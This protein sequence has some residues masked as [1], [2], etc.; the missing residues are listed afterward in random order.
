MVNVHEILEGDEGLSERE[1]AALNILAEAGLSRAF[2]GRFALTKARVGRLLS[3]AADL[4]SK[5]EG[6]GGLVQVTQP[7]RFKCITLEDDEV[8]HASDSQ[9]SMMKVSPTRA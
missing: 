2:K 7:A 5:I 6:K 9:P 8:G 3:F 1:K 4:A